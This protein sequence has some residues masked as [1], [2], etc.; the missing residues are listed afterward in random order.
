M[1][2]LNSIYRKLKRHYRAAENIKIDNDLLIY[3]LDLEKKE[4][5]PQIKNLVDKIVDYCDELEDIDS[6]SKSSFCNFLK[7]F[8]GYYPM[9]RQL[10]DLWPTLAEQDKGL[11][12][13]YIS[14]SSNSVPS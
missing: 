14:E 13:E 3:R 12:V 2:E 7:E 11:I 1:D 10:H 9:V 6:L 5:N 8:H 4:L